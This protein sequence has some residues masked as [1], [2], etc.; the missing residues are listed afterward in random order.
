MN[1]KNSEQKVESGFR[2]NTKSCR[3]PSEKGSKQV[4][5]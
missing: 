4:E 2:P 3:Q 1:T 5:K